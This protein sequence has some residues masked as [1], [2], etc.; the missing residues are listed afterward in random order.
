MRD[1]AVFERFRLV[2]TK[3]ASAPV[4]LFRVARY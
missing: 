3:N 4:L 1:L 2:E